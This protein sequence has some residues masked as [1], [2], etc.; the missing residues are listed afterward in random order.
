[1]KNIFFYLILI[2]QLTFSQ[3]GEKKTFRMA[4]MAAE[5]AE[6]PNDLNQFKDSIENQKIVQF[7]NEKKKLQEI[8]TFTDYPED[9]KADFEANKK[10]AEIQLKLI[11]SLEP[12]IKDFKYYDTILYS[13]SIIN[14]VF[15]EFEPYSYIYSV[16]FSNEIENNFET[17][18]MTNN[19]D[20]ILFFDDVK[21]SKSKNDFIMTSTIKLYSKKEKKLIVNQQIFGDTNSYGEI[22]TCGN[23]LSCLFI[24]MVRNGMENIIP[25]IIKSQK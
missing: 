13:V 23:P 6:I 1:M 12:H 19:L 2:T 5:N 11:D 21:A 10:S 4:I 18:T 9:M 20:Y 15:N 3:S 24:T 7:S 17:Y 14:L 16:P 8:L 25:T 22:W